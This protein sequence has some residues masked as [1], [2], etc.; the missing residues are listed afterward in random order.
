MT[1]GEIWWADFGIPFGSEPGFHRPVLIIQDDSFN[2][3]NINTVIVIPFT[4]NTILADS[5]GNIYVEKTESGLSK[6]SVLVVS[7]ISVL[8][9][10]RLV[11][12]E[13]KLHYSVMEEVEEGIKLILGLI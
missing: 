10:T 1:R 5:P 13:N 12:L 2:R 9:K 6:D 3:S 7:Q 8:D 11:S 4:T